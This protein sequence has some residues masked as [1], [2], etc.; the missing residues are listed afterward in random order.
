[1]VQQFTSAL[2]DSTGD[3]GSD[4]SGGDDDVTVIGQFSPSGDI[5]GL[6]NAA[7]TAVLLHKRHK[8][9][10]ELTTTA[11][12]TDGASAPK[13]TTPPAKIVRRS[14]NKTRRRT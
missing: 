7:S 14:R 2:S 3:P 11:T 9:G 1:M 4:E 13:L 5:P 8:M 10:Q 12:F 6:D